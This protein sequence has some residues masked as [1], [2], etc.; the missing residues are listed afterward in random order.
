MQK[1]YSLL[2]CFLWLSIFSQYNGEAEMKNFINSE[3]ERY[4]KMVDYNINPNTLNYDLRYQRLELEIDPNQVFVSGKVVSYFI[5]NQEISSI[6]FDL[7]HTLTVSEVKYHDINLAFSQLSTKEIKIDFPSNLSPN[8]QDSLSVSYSGVPTTGNRGLYFQT[9]ANGPVAFTVAEPYGPQEWFPTKQSLN[10]KIERVDLKI[11]TPSQYST[12]GNGKLIS[13]T[14]LPNNKIQTFWRTDYPIPAYLIA[15]GVT[16]Y[17]KF[18]DTMGN[19][20]FPF[21]NYLFPAT[22]ANNGVL[23]NIEWTKTVMNTFEEYFGLYPYRNEKYGH[24]EFSFVGAGMEHATMSSMGW[25]TQ[26]IIAHELAHQWFGDKITCGAWNDIWLNEGF[27]VFSVHLSREKLYNTHEEFM[28]YLADQKNI[29][30]NLPDG[31]VYVPDDGL[32]SE[33]RIFDGRLTYAKGGYA[34]RMLKWILGDDLFYQAIR[35]YNSRPDLAYNYAKTSDLQSSIQLSTG[36]DLTYFFNDW[37][38]GQGYPT[39]TIKWKQMNN[40]LIFNVN[41]AQSHN[42]VSFFEMPLPFKVNGTNGEVAYFKLDNT[43]NNQNFEENINFI[44]SSVEFNYE[45]Q[46][47]ERNSTVALDPALSV[48]NS[49]SQG[50][51]IYPNPVKDILNIEGLQSKQPYEII[52]I[53]GKLLKKGIA[54]SSINIFGLPKGVY[55]LK[56]QGRNIKFIKE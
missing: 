29:I 51:R 36:K 30:T 4:S 13:E 38:Y 24:M 26:D 20:P 55:L 22:A 21:V 18:N 48:E 49:I 14:A 33:S 17:V 2:I 45:Y 40:K 12:A 11:T 27:A 50:I 44:V 41:Q 5:P 19:P 10:D 46:I 34:L 35:E 39:Y 53:E 43:S 15:I 25:W 9:H 52:N 32:A 7:T 3:A 56:L 16:N 42:S 8:V 54:Q 37:I 6:Y 23:N 31:S 1:L 28:N 47:L